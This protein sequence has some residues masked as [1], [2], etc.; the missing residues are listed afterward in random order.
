MMMKM[1]LP[2]GLLWLM[3]FAACSAPKPQVMDTYTAVHFV[4]SDYPLRGE[5][6]DW[7]VVSIQKIAEDSA[8]V[9][10]RSRADLKKPSLTFSG[11][12]VYNDTRDT[13]TVLGDGTPIF[14]SAT[15]SVLSISSPWEVVLRYYGSGGASLAG[16]YTL[17]RQALD[18]TQLVAPVKEYVFCYPNSPIS[19]QVAYDE[20]QVRI[21][22][23]GLSQ[24]NDT[25]YHQLDGHRVSHIIVED[26]DVDGYPELYV[27]THSNTPDRYGSLIAYSPN[28][29]KSLSRIYLPQI[30]DDKELASEY[31]GHDEMEI[32]EGHLVR[33]FRIKGTDKMRQI[34]YKL[35]PREAGWELYADKV[36]IY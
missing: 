13:I 9:Q 35:L 18:S 29:G 27:F 34:Q 31:A 4:T 33:R 7:S 36:L 19:Y 30:A 3:I 2:W 32:M 6:Y 25:L 1:L 20:V 24:V 22:T 10:V 21:S 23:Q 5:G 12:G 17:L 15:D 28:K 14:F 8:Y 26:L 16:Q 11:T